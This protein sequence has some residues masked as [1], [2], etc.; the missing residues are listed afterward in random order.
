VNHF[1]A[2]YG[3]GALF[4]TVA[5]E[6]AG[7]PVPGETSLLAA[8]AL[9]S[10]GY[11]DIGRVIV[12]AAIAAIVGDNV[13][14]WVGRWGGRWLLG[15]S[16]IIRRYAERVLPKAEQ[17]FARYGGAAVFLARFVTG[18]RVTAAWMAGISRMDWWRFLF[19]NAAGAVVWA[20]VVSLAG[21]LLGHAAFAVVSRYQWLG[22]AAALLAMAAG[23]A[24]VWWR[25]HRSQRA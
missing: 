23:A 14:Y 25:R 17:F 20:T 7:L 18:L 13:G 24:I 12:I 9:A 22:A 19:W 1:I 2:T 8:S 10:R 11:F 6:S 4:M 3:L 21:Y 16:A 5:L 15:R